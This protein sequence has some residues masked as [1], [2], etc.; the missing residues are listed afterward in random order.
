MAHLPTQL[1]TFSENESSIY[2]LSAAAVGVIEEACA[3]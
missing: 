1:H 2:L 3:L